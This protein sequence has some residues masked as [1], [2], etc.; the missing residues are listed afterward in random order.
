MNL[1]EFLPSLGHAV[2][3]SF[4][5]LAALWV[6]FQVLQVLFPRL[7]AGSRSKLALTFLLGGFAWFVASIFSW[8]PSIS[9]KGSSM[10]LVN[11]PA[12]WNQWLQDVFP[13]ASA[14][15]LFLLII[16][17]AN[18]IRNYRY[19]SQIRR[20]GL[21]KADADLR[22]FVQRLS[23]RMG[24]GRKVKLWLSTRVQTPVTI[25]FIRPVILLPIAAV[26]QLDTAQVEAILLHELAH[27]RRHDYLLNF[28]VRLIQTLLYFNP[29]V[30]A[31][32]RIIESE[33]EKSCDEMVIQFQYNAHQYASAL[34]E[35][36]R[37]AVPAS[38]VLAV[39]AAGTRRGQQLLGR[40]ENIL[41]IKKQHRV[42]A[43]RLT[44][45]IV[46]FALLASVHF[47]LD[48]KKADRDTEFDDM[49]AF[50][51]SPFLSSPAPNSYQPSEG[52]EPA[53]AS[54]AAEWADA[55]SEEESPAIADVTV[56]DEPELNPA[57]ASVS[58][59]EEALHRI[60]TEALQ[61][62]SN[63]QNILNEAQQAEVE[64][65]L[66][67][68]QRVLQEIQWK[69]TE[70]TIADALTEAE[71]ELV[72]ERLKQE[73][74]TANWKKLEENLQQAYARIDWPTLNTNLQLAVDQIRID[75]LQHVVNLALVGLNQLE[76]ELTEAK[77]T[78]IPDTDVT[79][80]A[81]SVRKKALAQKLD[82]LRLAAKPRKIIRL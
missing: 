30:R 73:A 32:A 8:S 57:A 50:M 6:L 25:G 48:W 62:I 64:K 61:F 26:S 1:S 34:L 27:I 19:V 33:R 41:G 14:I 16:P 59:T 13:Y 31:F 4:W 54:S 20:Q 23:E 2:L 78:S 28:L 10:A 36:E 24:I 63:R 40:V 45:L 53:E 71:K 3:N 51:N 56:A 37:A 75:S 65:A 17:V 22:I 70:E 7:S 47:L 82:T 12:Q 18:F 79:L 43:M 81:I 21:V 11:G 9:A 80:E 39:A 76:K 46:A 49:T 55:G 38:P 44:G 67:A 66:K 35:L 42:S 69:A 52:S 58:D 72:R 77:A 29:F 60:S 68:S 5:Q 74:E 15:Y